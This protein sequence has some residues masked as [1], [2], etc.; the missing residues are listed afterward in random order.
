MLTDAMYSSTPP[1]VTFRARFLGLLAGMTGG[2][3]SRNADSVVGNFSAV[4]SAAPQLD[5]AWVFW[6]KPAR[7]RT[8]R[9]LALL[10]TIHNSHALL[11]LLPNISLS[12]YKGLP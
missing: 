2:K 5:S 8:C 9:D 12:I 7:Q 4:P 1:N 6:G 11:P 10:G 3:P